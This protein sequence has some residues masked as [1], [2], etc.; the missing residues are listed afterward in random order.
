[1]AFDEGV[2][3][4]LRKL[5]ARRPGVTE[6]KMF[7]GLAFMYR[8]H[9][10]VGIIGESLMARVGP[11]AYVAALKRPFVREMDFTGKPMKGYV[12]VAPAGYESDADLKIWVDRC[13]DF[14]AS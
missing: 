3:E 2:A 7:G 8:D 9:M 6:K 13:L 5:F 10:L 14:N 4:R 11:D 1:M 12:Y